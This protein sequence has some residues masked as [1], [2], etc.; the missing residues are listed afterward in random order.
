MNTRSL[1]ALAAALLLG[2]ACAPA[3]AAGP[4]AAPADPALAARLGADANGMRPDVLVILKTGPRRVPDGPEREAMF[5]G[6][7]ANMERLA[8]AGKLAVAGPF[9]EDPQQWRGMF[10][11]ATDSIEEAQALVATDPLV[12]TGEMVAE[13]H[14]LYSTA[15]L[16]AV[17]DIHEQIA[18]EE[19]AE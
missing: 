7:F 5:Q 2:A 9:Q 6:H 13:Y 11:F 8:A 18:A 14:R 4:Q 10:V 15:A 12:R 1:A 16:M 19:A 17:N 3:V